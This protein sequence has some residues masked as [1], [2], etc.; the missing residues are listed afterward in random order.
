MCDNQNKNK[1]Y[2]H[3]NNKLEGGESSSQF[4]WFTI[5]EIEL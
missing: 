2:A 3:T 4:Q 1:F 5:A